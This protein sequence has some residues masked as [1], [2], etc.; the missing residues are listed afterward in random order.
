MAANNI[1]EAY[2]ALLQD[3]TLEKISQDFA[4]DMNIVT[5]LAE[6]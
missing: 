5:R 4:I 2:Y 3:G 6:N 1:L